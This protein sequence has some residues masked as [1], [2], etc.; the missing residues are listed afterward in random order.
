MLS[1]LPRVVDLSAFACG[2]GI[3]LARSRLIRD[4]E[5]A[6]PKNPAIGR[7]LLSISIGVAYLPKKSWTDSREHIKKCR[8]FQEDWFLSGSIRKG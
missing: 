2:D 6:P 4:H 3:L 1:D 8:A 7:R 5:P